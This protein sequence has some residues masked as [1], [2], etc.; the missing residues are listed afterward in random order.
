MKPK[1]ETIKDR[2]KEVYESMEGVVRNEIDD[3]RNPHA[4]IRRLIAAYS[5]AAA[6]VNLNPAPLSDFVMLTPLHTAMVLHVGHRMGYELTTENAWMVLKEI[7]A[8]IGLS[9]AGRLAANVALKIGLPFVGG[10]LRAPAV[11]AVTYGVGRVAEEYFTRK[12]E[13]LDFDKKTAR[14]VFEQAVQEG[15]VEGAH[16]EYAKKKKTAAKKKTAEKTV[17]VKQTAKKSTAKKTKKS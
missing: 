14:E 2:V 7:G 9:L 1:L 15:R 16:A 4:S 11:F 6:A 12:N 13:G 10:Y 3:A 8:A 17:A 5:G